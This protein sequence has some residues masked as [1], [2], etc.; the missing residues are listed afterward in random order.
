MTISSVGYFGSV[1]TSQWAALS[2][3]VG[4]APCVAGSGDWKP[5]TVSGVDRTVRIASGVGYA[6][7]VMV[8]S[9]ATA[10]VQLD[11]LSTGATRWDAVVARRDW[12][13][14]TTSFVKVNGSSAKAVP[15]LTTAA[16]TGTSDQLVALAQVTGGTQ[17]PTQ[18]IDCRRALDGG[19]F[20]QDAAKLL[21]LP[22]TDTAWA[23]IT[24]ASGIITSTALSGT[25]TPAARTLDGQVVL[26]GAFA[27]SPETNGFVNGSTTLC[28]L[29]TL[30]RPDRTV[31]V[32]AACEQRASYNTVRLQIGSNGV[33]TCWVPTGVADFPHWVAFDGIAFAPFAS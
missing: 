18:L 27:R 14:S 33:V 25:Q 8:T 15:T 28:T 21:G 24:P 2:R 12:T 5:T 10:D 29:D 32:V 20:N 13:T 11:T 31:E 23:A 19:V 30:Y 6:D 4:H 17:V 26:R 1:D 22:L 3:F 9:D 7:G 16:G